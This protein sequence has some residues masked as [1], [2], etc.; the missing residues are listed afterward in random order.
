[1]STHSYSSGIGLKTLLEYLAV[2][3]KI[4][5]NNT[6]DITSL[7]QLNYTTEATQ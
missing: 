4:E 3:K 2:G 5:V 7:F 1:M 6:T